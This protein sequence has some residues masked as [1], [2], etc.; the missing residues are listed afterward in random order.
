MIGGSRILADS[1]GWFSRSL[2]GL[3]SAAGGSLTR[4]A[5]AE[6][7]ASREGVGGSGKEIS[8]SDHPAAVGK[9]LAEDLLRWCCG[10]LVLAERAEPADPEVQTCKQGAEAGASH[11]L[12]KLVI[13]SVAAGVED[14]DSN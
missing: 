6:A 7:Q 9:S 2:T 4:V 12:G 11:A 8:E 1:S 5:Q 14:P 13:R 10:H 3:V